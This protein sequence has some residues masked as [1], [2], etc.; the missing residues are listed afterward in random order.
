MAYAIDIFPKDLVA[1]PK[2]VA[3]TAGIA[4]ERFQRDSLSS[5]PP[6]Q[7]IHETQP[8]VYTADTRLARR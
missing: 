8:A 6:E 5:T 1:V 3:L 4:N 7:P 2:F